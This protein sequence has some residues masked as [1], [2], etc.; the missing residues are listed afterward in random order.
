MSIRVNETTLQRLNQERCRQDSK[1]GVK[2]HNRFVWLT[3]LTEEVGEVS[4]AALENK[5]LLYGDELIQVAAVA[6]AAYESFV[7]QSK[8]K[9]T[10]NE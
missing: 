2:D 1:W 3:I 8:R 7:R 10:G 5:G 9:E 6:I 4:K